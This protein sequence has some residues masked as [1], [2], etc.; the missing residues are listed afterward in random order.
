MA[1]KFEEIDVSRVFDKAVNLEAQQNISE[2]IE[3]YELLLNKCPSHELC[4]GLDENIV[5]L[6]EKA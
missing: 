6:R 4:K 5:S 1:E 2:A 3:L